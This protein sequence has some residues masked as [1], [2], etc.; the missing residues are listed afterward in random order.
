[1]RYLEVDGR[2]VSRVGLGCWQFG[3]REW[4]YGR[5]YGE[6]ETLA[7]VARARD[8]GVTLFD[9]AELYGGGRSETLLGRALGDD[10]EALVA[11]KYLPV[12]P[13]P[14]SIVRH[15]R[16]SLE[17]LGR[18][19]VWLYQLHWPNPLVPISVQMRGMRRVLEEGLAEHVGVSNYTLRWWR[20]AD[21]ALGRPVLSNQV[22]YHLLDRR[23]ERR[24]LPFAEAQKRLVIA[25]SPLAQG[26]LSGR[27]S[28]DNLPRDVRRTNSLFT[29]AN[30]RRAEPVV[31]AVREVAK[32][33]GATPSQ[34]ALAYVLSRP[35]T[36]VIPGAKSVAQVEA[37]VAAADLDLDAE[38]LAQLRAAAAG[39]R[40]DRLR[41]VPQFLAGLVR[42]H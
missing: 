33:H 20:A 11:T 25:Y 5:E 35:R 18:N 40:P 4:G 29:P 31:A 27:Y 41:A 36:V 14:E 19:R 6:A 24:L 13:L 32:R 34:V 23:A 39:F 1:M 16:R 7:V 9:T 10:P 26:V 30:L 8:L 37:N 22:R 28:P 21:R 38:D 3:S 15:C 17:R 42:R 12:L 2:R